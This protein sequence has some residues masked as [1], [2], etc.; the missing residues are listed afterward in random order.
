M[1][2]ILPCTVVNLY[3][4]ALGKR[5]PRPFDKEYIINMV[6]NFRPHIPH[7][8]LNEIEGIQKAGNK[9]AYLFLIHGSRVAINQTARLVHVTVATKTNHTHKYIKTFSLK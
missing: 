3:V 6:S 7:R 8:C 2:V 1:A 4:S 5:Y 9:I